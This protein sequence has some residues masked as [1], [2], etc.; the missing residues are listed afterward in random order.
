MTN[1]TKRFWKGAG[2]VSAEMLTGMILFSGAISWIIYLVRPSMRKHKK[3]DLKVFEVVQKH[4][5]EAN[6]L[7]MR[8]VSRLGSHNF[9]IPANLIIIA[10]FLFIRRHSWFSI[11]VASVSLSSLALMFLFKA[12][13]R[14]ERPMDPLLRMAKGKSFP[15]GH[16]LMSTTFYGLLIYITSKSIHSKKV[17]IP[18]V[19]SF[20]VLIQLIGLSRVYLRVHYASDVVVGYIA[21]AAWLGISLPMLARI[22]AYN[23][24]R[25]S[26]T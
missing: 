1:S 12:L 10:Y 23:K 17:E 11:R 16:A 20:F 22:E 19:C 5:S 18:L 25:V 26:I 4:T 21:G 6:T 15:S 2:V 3:L 14:R 7:V 8:E 24:R 13:F 9:L